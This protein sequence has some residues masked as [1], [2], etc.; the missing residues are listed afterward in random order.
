MEIITTTFECKFI[1]LRKL[2]IRFKLINS[3]S[4]FT[5]LTVKEMRALVQTILD[6]L[7][8]IIMDTTIMLRK[9]L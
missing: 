8:Y 3:F 6:N 7:L 4:S 1:N 2:Q 5:L 9:A